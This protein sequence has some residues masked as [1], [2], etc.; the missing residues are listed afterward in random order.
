MTLRVD[1]SKEQVDELIGASSG[2]SSTTVTT[3]SMK[4]TM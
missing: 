4:T 3:A 1:L 2:I